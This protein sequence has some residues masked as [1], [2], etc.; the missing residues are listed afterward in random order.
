MARDSWIAVKRHLPEIAADIR[1]ANADSVDANQ[2]LART[3]FGG[4]RNLDQFELTG[5]LE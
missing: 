3:R 4:F 5:L 2:R 1:A